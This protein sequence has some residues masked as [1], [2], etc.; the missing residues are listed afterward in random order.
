MEDPG[1]PDHDEGPDRLVRPYVPNAD[2]T[3]PHPVLA[4]WLAP[5]EPVTVPVPGDGPAVEGAGAPASPGSGRRQK[6]ATGAIA[7][8]VALAGL[9]LSVLP[10]HSLALP[11]GKRAAP[12]ATMTDLL[13]RV[14]S[15]PSPR[16][17]AGRVP[18][19][20]GTRNP[21]T[22]TAR[23]PATAA[24][25]TAPASSAVPAV[26]SPAVAS[27]AVTPSASARVPA[28]PQ[29]T[30]GSRVSLRATTACCTTYYIRHDSSDNRVVITQVT[31]GS[32]AA[33]RE[34]A[35]WI[36]RAGLDNSA[37]VSFESV[38]EPG[39]YLRHYEFELYLAPD[40]GSLQFA[41]DAT[42]CPRPGNGGSGTSFESVNYPTMY[43]RHYDYV[44]YLAGNGGFSPWDT[45]ALWPYDSTWAVSQPWG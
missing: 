12:R 37:C 6:V 30:P 18:G 20:A 43:I 17:S 26:S 14:T 39:D 24:S 23:A 27:P 21:A 2:L 8:L 32:S 1:A 38:N 3:A 35:T 5:S 34:D 45:P 16:P 4:E 29:L 41:M 28:A 33:Y 31:P 13:G 44:V 36:V 7:V 19:T 25:V 40:D 9:L 15:A 22:A 42:F 10:L 11:A